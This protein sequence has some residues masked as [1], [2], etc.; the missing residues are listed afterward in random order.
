MDLHVYMSIFQ[1]LLS[2]PTGSQGQL[3]EELRVRSTQ[4]QAAESSLTSTAS[5]A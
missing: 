2:G 5:T 4:A 3:W 1:G